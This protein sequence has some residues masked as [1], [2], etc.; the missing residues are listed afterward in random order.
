MEKFFP[1]DL[2]GGDQ[3]HQ[4]WPPKIMHHGSDGFDPHPGDLME[5]FFSIK[6]L[7]HKSCTLDLRLFLKNIY[8]RNKN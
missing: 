5:K 2:Q 8:F 3:I 6:S 1:S 4:I 7:E